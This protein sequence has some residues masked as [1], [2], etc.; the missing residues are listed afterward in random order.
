MSSQR[1]TSGFKRKPQTLRRVTVPPRVSEKGPGGPGAGPRA[2]GHGPPRLPGAPTRATRPR[3]PCALPRR[4]SHADDSVALR[5]P[6]RGDQRRTAAWGL[7][8]APERRSPR[9]EPSAAGRRSAAE[10]ALVRGRPGSRA[11]AHA[12]RD[13]RPPRGRG[14]RGVRGAGE[15]KGG[16]GVASGRARARPAARPPPHPS[17]AR[18]KRFLPACSGR[19]DLTPRWRTARMSTRPKRA[20]CLFSTQR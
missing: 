2:C 13:P 3:G 7:G 10:R 20:A 19:R 17:A 15:G 12:R 11:R 5:G 8:P 4:H 6:P 1:C 9:P 14:Q 16:G 18:G